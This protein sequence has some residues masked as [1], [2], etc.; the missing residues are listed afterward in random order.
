MTQ[1]ILSSKSGTHIDIIWNEWFEISIFHVRQH[2]VHSVIVNGNS[3]EMQ[4]VV[5]LKIFHNGRLLQKLGH[6]PWSDMEFWKQQRDHDKSK[7]KTENIC[8]Q[9]AVIP[10]KTNLS[11]FWWQ[12]NSD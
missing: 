5:V 11:M 7:L 2:H 4:D 12:R 10:A 3:Q 6:I 9:M 1:A 8:L